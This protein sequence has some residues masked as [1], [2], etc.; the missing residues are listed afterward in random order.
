MVKWPLCLCLILLVAHT[1]ADAAEELSEADF[2]AELPTV[3]TASRL[4]QP[5]IDA[6]NSVTVID[7]K[8][9]EAS[10]Y[11]NFS[12]LFRLVPGMYVGQVKGWFH[13]VSNAM[14]D[15]Y[16]RRMQ[17]MVDGRSIYLPSFGGVRWDVLPLAIE[18]IERIEVV[19]GPNAASFGANAF[20]GIINIIT[21]HPDDVAGRML[22]MVSGDH[23]HRE[24]WFRWAGGTEGN[25]HRL[26][27]G[28]REDG[29]MTNQLD[30]ERTNTLN[31][32]GDFKL[33]SRQNLS[34][35]FGLLEGTRGFDIGL[36][37]QSLPYQQDVG[38][39][40]LQADY[41]LELDSG[42]KVQAKLY[43]NHLK[44]EETIPTT[45][46]PGSYYDAGLLADRVHAEIQLDSQLGQGMRSVVGA[47]L[48]RDGVES[49]LYW[50]SPSRLNAD[51][52][53]LF[54]HLEWR[55]SDA[56][57]VNA[58]AFWEDYEPVGNGLSP[59]ITLHWQPSP[60]HTFRAS[61]GK[62]FRN[63]VLYET[64]G[65]NRIRLL[66]ANGALLLTTRPFV[67]ASGNVK[68]E[69]II[70]H[71][72]AYL[73][74][75]PERGL[76]LD[77]RLHHENIENF[78]SL[79]CPTGVSSDCK[80]SLHPKTYLAR[81]WMNI[82]DA[83]QQ[84]VEAQLKWQATSN[85]DVLA[86]Y[87]FLQIDSGFDEKRYSPPHLSGVHL[88]HRFPGGVD[89]TLSH[90][91]VSSFEPI[92]SGVLPAYKRL[93]ARIAKRFKLDGLRG[94]VALTWE[95]LTGA[96][97]EYS[98]NSPDNLFDSRAYIHFQLDF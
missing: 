25:S 67:L 85:T 58:G 48:R 14:A 47:Y 50:N 78:I 9:I 84:G 77:L 91:W 12:D 52:K 30:D 76:T 26:T 63:P 5:L 10:G 15:E 71:E 95:N 17:V 3:L 4:T 54:G 98:D 49:M 62:A 23:D 36:S 43:F 51:S 64:S 21:R 42:S 59:R 82:G 46:A 29:G 33:G 90:Y 40:F 35:Q 41:Q 31:Y 65:D 27:L 37:G 11:H 22:R 74:Q 57:L 61:I 39:H 8:L 24:G 18:D 19:R 68:P 89:M 81:D 53:G 1:Q 94:Q 86:N 56:W 6:P 2:F 16:A 34:L 7:R 72:L 70:S 80:S 97:L 44:T 92:G 79:E 38:S 20:T 96:Y 73:G 32:R 75:W 28:R 60:Q 88:M 87:A 93:D 83:T 45:L 66:A 55:L 13:N 69:E